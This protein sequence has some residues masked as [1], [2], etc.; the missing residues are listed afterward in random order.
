MYIITGADGKDMVNTYLFLYLSIENTTITHV[1][2]S[3]HCLKDPELLILNFHFELQKKK[4]LCELNET[5][6][7]FHLRVSILFMVCVFS[8]RTKEKS[9]LQTRLLASGRVQL[10]HVSGPILVLDPRP[11]VLAP[12]AFESTF[13][14]S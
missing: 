9:E 7:L 8:N 6:L 14:S 13:P 5:V 12:A 4:S 2:P 10:N 11:E 3:T 1:S